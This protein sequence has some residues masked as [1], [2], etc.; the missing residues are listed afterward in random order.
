MQHDQY[1]GGEAAMYLRKSR[2]EEY[3]DSA[4]EVLQK[5][6]AKLTE[7]A[8][9]KHI[10]VTDVYEEVVSGESI[11][12][13]PEMCRLLEAVRQKKYSAVLCMD[14][15]RLGRGNMSDQGT[16]LETFQR[17]AT[18]IVTPDKTFDLSNDSD[19]EL[20]EFRAFFARREWKVIR[21]RMRRGLM[22]TIEAG[23]YV[24]N[25]PYGY[26]RCRVGKPPN[27]LP[28]LEIVP[29][30]A[31]FV[32]YMYSRYAQGIGAD[33]I[34]Q[35][36]NA[37]G[38]V[39]RRNALWSRTTVRSIL[40]NPT[41][42][43]YVAWNRVKHFRP[44]DNGLDK[45]HVKYMAEDD[46]IMVQGLHQAII[47][48]EE[49]DA[50]QRRRK[51]RYIVPRH[52]GHCKNSLAG[53][54]VCS[55]CGRKMQRMGDSEGHPRLVCP[56]KG[57]CAGA[58]HSYVEQ[59][60]LNALRI[61]MEA[62]RLE[63][64][65]SAHDSSAQDLQLLAGLDRELAKIEARLPRLYTLLE[66]GVYDIDTFRARKAAAAEEVQ[67]LQARRAELEARINLKKTQNLKNA[68]E[69]IDNVLTLWPS[70]D[71]AGRNKLLKSV[72]KEIIYTKPKK[73]GPHAFELKI[74]PLNFLW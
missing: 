36:L 68:A 49:W 46:W 51:S 33:T 66:E 2:A 28:T 38:S 24:S 23:G 8:R 47:P 67:I 64:D 44:G 4:E 50:V 14:I 32:K 42:K 37:M 7:L 56:T 30:E 48:E 45:H 18:L 72:L 60:L 43:G 13:R 40:R 61:R 57:C 3:P 9:E 69:D 1:L 6:R 15:D 41:F 27:D 34:S 25:A 31:K 29:E 26:R 11:A 12:K 59:S 20:S 70:S 58:N 21:K 52:D 63:A 16:M 19:E 71:A 54:V 5:H 55:V 35:E 22:Q 39:P 73:T 17:S 10:A 53:L 65:Q 62:L 74:V